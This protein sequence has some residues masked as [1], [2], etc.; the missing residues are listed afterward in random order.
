MPH[1]RRPK[2]CDTRVYTVLVSCWCRDRKHEVLTHQVAPAHYNLI[3]IF[4]RDILISSWYQFQ[5]CTQGMIRYIHV[6]NMLFLLLVWFNYAWILNRIQI[7]TKHVLYVYYKTVVWPITHWY[8]MND[9]H[10]AS[11]FAE[12]YKAPWG[13]WWRIKMQE[14]SHLNNQWRF[15]LE[16]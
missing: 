9:T 10:E 15:H 2:E 5:V 6:N 3:W 13:C 1:S 4:A 14:T 11:C 7:D 8:E 16:D 12:T